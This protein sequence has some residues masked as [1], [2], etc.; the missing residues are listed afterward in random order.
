MGLLDTV[1]PI[2]G[3][4]IAIAIVLI[5]SGMAFMAVV[6]A[7]IVTSATTMAEILVLIALLVGIASASKAAEGA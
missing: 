5:I 4:V 7:A 6:S 2:L 3:Y 1:Q